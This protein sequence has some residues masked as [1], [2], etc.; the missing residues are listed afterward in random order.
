MQY[1]TV[2][3]LISGHI[4]ITQDLILFSPNI[5]D[6]RNLKIETESTK[7][8]KYQFCIDFSAIQDVL[9]VELPKKDCDITYEIDKNFIKDFYFEI[10]VSTVRNDCNPVFQRIVEKFGEK[11]HSIATL[12]LKLDEC[13][14]KNGCELKDY[15]KQ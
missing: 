1:N 7:L 12:F 5:I 9:V 11:G 2:H 10:C 14:D 3:G 4:T 13:F 15:F 6:P 8:S